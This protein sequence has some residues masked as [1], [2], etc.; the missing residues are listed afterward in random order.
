MAA[1]IALGELG[2]GANRAEYLR[3]QCGALVLAVALVGPAASDL[4]SQMIGHNAFPALEYVSIGFGTGLSRRGRHCDWA[5]RVS[6]LVLHWTFASYTRGIRNRASIQACG[7][8]IDDRLHF[9]DR[10]GWLC[11]RYD[12]LGEGRHI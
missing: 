11:V 9:C 1:L 5:G 10:L 8:F 7:A 2:H 12:R 4:K 6:A 3:H